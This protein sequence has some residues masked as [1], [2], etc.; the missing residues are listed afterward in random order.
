MQ[1]ILITGGT[2][3][4]GRHLTA[5]LVGMGKEVHLLVRSPQSLE[6]LGLLAG[7]VRAHE[8]D[9]C[10]KASL[11][12][13]VAAARADVVYNLAAC[14][15]LRRP[16]PDLSDV[17]EA[18]DV[19]VLGAI[20]FLRVLAQANKPPA[21]MIQAA[22]LAEYGTGPLP[23][24]EDQREE[25][26]SAYG[27]SRLMQ[28]HLLQ[29]LKDRLPFPAV[30]LRLALT[31]GPG[32]SPGFMIPALIDALL[33]GERYDIKSG[34]VTRDLIHVDDIVDAFL[35]SLNRPDLGGE[36]INISTGRE[37]RMAD[38]GR[39]I[40][41]LTGVSG[42]LTIGDRRAVGGSP[43]LFAAPD[44]AL[45]LLGWRAGVGF[46]DG[47]RHTIAW[48]RAGKPPIEAPKDRLAHATPEPIPAFS[49][50]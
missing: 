46:E 31:Y 13:A 27:L 38:V 2:G 11:E 21:L 39:L 8:G 15:D 37:R 6:R 33:R 35:A 25:P 17:T 12:R 14:T 26:V 16:R 32:Q 24:R 23:Y 45:D 40:E 10:D 49:T 4:I 48:H 44:K 9:L 1:R 5:R 41:R 47:L 34:D 19:D 20:D 22:S 18:L 43:R 50:G 3:F 29:S 30:M 7:Q 42:L 36:V 28:T